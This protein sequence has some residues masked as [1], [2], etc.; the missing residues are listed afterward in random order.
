[1]TWVRQLRLDI[2]FYM[3]A[4]Y[5]R[6]AL[7]ATIVGVLA[8]GIGLPACLLTIIGYEFW[9]AL[10]YP[11]ARSL[12]SLQT[13]T[14][15]AATRSFFPYTTIRA[16]QQRSL[17]I[18]RLG[19]YSYRGPLDFIT[20]QSAFAAVETLNV[21][22]Q[23]FGAL[24]ITPQAGRT[25][26]VG[27]DGNIS[28]LDADTVS[29]SSAACTQ[30]SSNPA[31]MVGRVIDLDGHPYTVIGVMPR[32]MSFP[33]SDSGSQIW[34]PVVPE[35]QN[36]QSGAAAY[37]V[38]GRLRGGV[39]AGAAS[40]ELTSILISTRWATSEPRRTA[41]RALVRPY[42]ATIV[43]PP[44]KRVLKLLSVAAGILWLIG[45]TNASALLLARAM[46]YEDD[47]F[48][49]LALGAHRWQIV[50]QLFV[51]SLILMG[52]ATCC[53]GGVAFALLRFLES[54]RAMRVDISIPFHPGVVLFVVLAAIGMLSAV[55]SCVWPSFVW[56][57]VGTRGFGNRELRG[58]TRR[59]DHHTV[60]GILVATQ[61][62]LSVVLLGSCA[63]LFRSVFQLGHVPL[64]FVPNHVLVAD[65]VTSPL[66]SRDVEFGSHML[67]PMI[68]SLKHLPSVEAAGLMTTPPL[69]NNMTTEVTIR[70]VGQGDGSRR[71]IIMLNVV[72][73]D[74]QRVLKS[75]IIY[76]RF[77]NG[78]DR[79]GT[80]LVTVVN[81][82]FV[83]Q[84]FPAGEK[85]A[86]IIGRQVRIDDK[87]IAT[88]IG[89]SGDMRQASL[90]KAVEPEIQLS[91]DQIEP[92]T[93]LYRSTI[94]IACGLAVRT[95]S[96]PGVAI[97]EIRRLLAG[98]SPELTGS[99][100]RTLNGVIDDSYRGDTVSAKL[101]GVFGVFALLLC[102][103]GIYGLMDYVVRRRAREV[104]IRVALGAR[105]SHVL[106]VI[107][108]EALVAVTCGLV[109]GLA[110]TVI[111]AHVIRS[112]LYGV[113]VYDPLVLGAMTGLIVIT[114]VCAGCGPARQAYRIAPAEMLRS[115]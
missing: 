56:F 13:V 40:G 2:R 39:T 21:G 60:R 17:A 41:G 62:A 54:T 65:L 90:V 29:L 16:W 11:E 83:R 1:M 80:P 36:D 26:L 57:R 45:C 43:S 78:G 19:Y 48:V 108:G 47:A 110:G 73:S 33:F 88:I 75:Q 52:I 100:I 46:S 28:N 35:K 14:A 93:E 50:K 102:V 51:E 37:G 81:A 53:G 55:V 15:N 115:E 58:N 12:V 91:I 68:Q 44:L 94:G 72:S 6:R 22:G 114:G 103:G 59:S 25:F 7:S 24:G 111:C 107:I 106:K 38:I 18:E 63:L 79:I 71:D 27:S 95:A 70:L 61:V 104:A 34:I 31:S 101:L 82:A 30:L 67:T 64:G 23:L 112:F 87:Y 97:P 84:Y 3:L 20:Y 4:I 96:A 9:P 98:A 10:P 76:G 66:G 89:V 49:R 5:R 42:W 8:L 109:F 105:R 74:I 99:L 86:R 69:D 85:P 92:S 77:F 32:A 113:A